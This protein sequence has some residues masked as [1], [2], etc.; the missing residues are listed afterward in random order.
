[1]S[2]HVRKY[3]TVPGLVVAMLFLGIAGSAVFAQSQRTGGPTKSGPG[4][5]VYFVDLKDGATVPAK[6]KL[7]CWSRGLFR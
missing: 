1:M 5:E 6:L 7:S 3:R 4:A 2:M